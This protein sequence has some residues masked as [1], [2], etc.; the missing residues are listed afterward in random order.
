MRDLSLYIYIVLLL[1]SISPS[2]TLQEIK[3]A[4]PLPALSIP[5]RE[6]NAMTGSE[7]MD[8]IS[9]ISFEERELRIL[10]EISAG[11]IPEFLRQLSTITTRFED[12]SG[13]SYTVTFEVM[14]DYLSIGSN[15]DFCR[16]PIGPITAQKLADIFGATMPTRKLVDKIYDQS[17]IKL[18]PVPYYPVDNQNELVAKFIEHNV[19]IEKQ[20]E[21][22]G[23]K[24]GNLTGGIK[25]DVVISNKIA[26][27]NRTHH[28]V[29][30]GWHKL[31]GEPIQPLYNGHIDSY[32]DYSHGIR[33]INSRILIDGEIY[34]FKDILS[35]DRMF[36]IISDEESPM[37][38]T[39]YL[40]RSNSN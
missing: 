4:Q 20:R 17:E 36:S 10:E 27:P 16:I 18:D 24:L 5:E 8:S 23:A 40:K 35:D 29:I 15:A 39:S 30:Y 28:V 9:D 21:E 1:F 7:F 26:D 37:I 38:K 25:K 12:S 22:K 34:D 6:P 33:F 13:K 32:T 14:P 3:E 19:A 2:P 31:N 11:N